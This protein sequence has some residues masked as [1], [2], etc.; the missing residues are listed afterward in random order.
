MISVCMPVYN[1]QELLDGALEMYERLY[2]QWNIE[3]SVCDDRSDPPVQDFETR[4][5]SV[6]SRIDGEPGW[7]APTRSI[8][9]A[10]NQSSGNIIVLTN[11]EIRHPSDAVLEKMRD[12]FNDWRD[13][14][15][16][17]VR[18][19]E[20]QEIHPELAPEGSEVNHC[21]MFS[22]KLWE[23]T[24]GFDDRYR[25]GALYED[26]DFLYRARAAGARFRTIDETVIH[27]RTKNQRK[28]G[29]NHDIF[30]QTWTL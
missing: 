2:W 20:G 30:T 14:V 7:K 24:R 12:N 23:E 29:R 3:I 26:I 9:M 16:C 5:K 1:R 13:Y 15:C 28:I 6:L 22:R 27:I 25:E 10:V 8:N 21:V 4:F 17:K 11:A 19:F 18:Q